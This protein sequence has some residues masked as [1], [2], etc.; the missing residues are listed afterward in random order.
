MCDYVC[1]YIYIYI[2][3][4]LCVCVW[5][6]LPLADLAGERERER[7]ETV[8]S[9]G[10]WRREPETFLDASRFKIC[11]VAEK[12]GPLP[13]HI[14][15]KSDSKRSARIVDPG[16]CFWLSMLWE[17]QLTHS[18]VVMVNSLRRCWVPVQSPFLSRHCWGVRS[19]KPCA[20]DDWRT[21]VAEAG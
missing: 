7:L 6:C 13:S 12:A 21:P 9:L 10:M 19:R 14:P 1:V 4:W 5:L 3:A 20:N 11:A 8:C 16:S 15:R 2:C 18:L 17:G